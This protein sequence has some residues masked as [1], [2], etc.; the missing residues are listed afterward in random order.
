MFIFSFSYGQEKQKQK[1][2]KYNTWSVGMDI[3]T[4][5][6]Y[7]DVMDYDFFPKK[8][9][10]WG[11]G[12]S[13][14]VNKQFSPF[15]GMQAHFHKGNLY[16]VKGK[17]TFSTKYIQYTI[18]SYFSITDLLFTNVR[19]KHINFYFLIGVGFID[20]RTLYKEGNTYVAVR[21]YNL[22]DLKPKLATSEFIIPTAIGMNIKLN[23][24]LDANVEIA[25]HNL[26]SS[27]FLDTQKGGNANDKFATSSIG[28]SYKFG[29]KKNHYL[30]WISSREKQEFE[31]KIA[32]KNKK[33]IDSL[34]YSLDKLQNKIKILDSIAKAIPQIE[35]DDDHDGVPNS[36]DHEPNTPAGNMVNFMGVSIHLKDTTRIEKTKVIVDT[37][38]A[39]DKQLL[40]S[41]YFDFNKS[42]IKQEDKL[43]IVEAAKLMRENPD[44]FL[45]IRGHTD[46]VGS[47]QYNKNLSMKRSQTVVDMLVYEFGISSSRF[48]RTYRG[49]TD[50]LSNQDDSI[51]RRVDFIIIK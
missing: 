6:S 21:G 15:F 46:K 18:N 25:L 39:P 26:V 23:P 4:S 36:Q 43:K 22:K 16:G 17:N 31:E 13:F 33:L 10:Y 42:E 12:A 20:F 24:Y 48:I 29:N 32:K 50:L 44:Y 7:T 40:F 37:I 41:I 1:K 34:N 27:D 3:G 28:I 45:E 5:I 11:S 35:A 14:T 8:F 9:K 30:A 38:I 47:I 2:I 49:K 19:K 51:N